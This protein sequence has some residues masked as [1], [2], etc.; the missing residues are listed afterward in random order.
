MDINEYYKQMLPDDIIISYKGAPSEELLN[1]ILSIADIK[2]ASIEQQSKL[3]KKVYHILVEVIQNVHHHYDLDDHEA[4]DDGGAII[5]I[6][7][8][9][10][11]GYIICTGNYVPTS[12]VSTLKKYLETINTLSADELKEHYRKQLDQG[13]FS[14]KGGAGLGILDIARRS[15]ER[16]DYE[17]KDMR[18]G[19]SFFSLKVKVFA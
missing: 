14:D 16:L 10:E 12:N 13:T 4:A 3:K 11:R 2:L 1:S 9:A 17:F 19:N 7:A 6:L 18:N 8:R 15:G 5:F